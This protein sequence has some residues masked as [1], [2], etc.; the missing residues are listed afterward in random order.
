MKTEYDFQ[1]GVRGKFFQPDASVRMPVHPVSVFMKEVMS[2]A[3]THA[4]RS[5]NFRVI[6]LAN[7]FGIPE[8][9]ARAELLEAQSEGRVFLSAWDGKRVRPFREWNN[10]ISAFFEAETGVV[11]ATIAG[12][13]E[14]ISGW[15]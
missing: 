7:L 2:Q 3:R 9:A 10:D 14:E 5:Y 4:P 11:R 8:R 15:L 6:E 12:E 1:N 13:G